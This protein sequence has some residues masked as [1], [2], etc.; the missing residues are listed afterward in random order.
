M[1]FTKLKKVR[2]RLPMSSC[3][4]DGNADTLQ[5][6]S[7]YFSRFQV[8]YKVCPSHGAVGSIDGLGRAS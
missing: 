1:P 2:D 4:S 5:Q 3:H 8:K 6:N 7:A